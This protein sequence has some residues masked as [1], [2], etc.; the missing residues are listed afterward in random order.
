MNPK[1]TL[2]FESNASGLFAGTEF[3]E[4]NSKMTNLQDG[5]VTDEVDIYSLYKSDSRSYRNSLFYVGKL[6]QK[7][8]LNMDFTY[9]DY[10]SNYTNEYFADG[11]QTTDER[12]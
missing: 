3:A 11:I 12:R 5:L 9:S 4:D 2:S 6:N 10:K 7:N 8:S 1:H